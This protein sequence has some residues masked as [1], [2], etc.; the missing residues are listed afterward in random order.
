MSSG[1]LSDLP[2]EGLGQRLDR[3]L[4][5]HLN[6]PRN[7]IQQWIRAGSVRVDGRP[8][9]ASHHLAAGER[10]EW[11]P[12]SRQSDVDI[13]PEPEALAILHEDS[14]VVV[15]DKPPELAVHP[16]AG[17]ASGTLVHRLVARYPEL[18]AVGGPGRPGIVHRLD[19]DTTGVM[20]VARTPTAYQSL[21][22][23]FEKRQV[24]KRYLGIVYGEPQEAEGTIDKPIGRHPLRRKR[25]TIRPDGRPAMTRYRSV[26]AA[27]GIALLE[28][29]LTTGRTHQI[30]VHL[31]AR[32]YPLVGD[33]TY[34]EARWK[35]LP[36]SVRAPLKDFPRPA[37]HAWR[38]GF[39]H[40]QSGQ[41]LGFEAPIPE[42]MVTLWQEVTGKDFPKNP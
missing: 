41:K 29:E 16:G 5:S 38:L 25:M 10:L 13:V 2:S 27:Q 30:R 28:L 22:T 3:F 35:E 15:V 24:D 19:Q 20:V 40:P 17:R 37:L 12:L 31:K 11:E 7:Q 36:Q 6:L 23:A 34:G 26:D 1:R 14:E 8:A 33:P 18:S 4:A 39:V 32:G 21:S 42:D 9:K